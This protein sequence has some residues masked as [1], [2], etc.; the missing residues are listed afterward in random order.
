LNLHIRHNLPYTYSVRYFLHRAFSS[1]DFLDQKP[2]LKQIVDTKQRAACT[3]D[4]QWLVGYCAGPA[5]RHRT[6]VACLIQVKDPV[7][8]PALAKLQQF[9]FLLEQWMEWM[10]YTETS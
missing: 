1:F 8:S 2:E 6:Q 7:L 10:G 4:Y 9:E 3:D 5:C